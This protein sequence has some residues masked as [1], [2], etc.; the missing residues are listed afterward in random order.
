MAGGRVCRV[1]AAAARP[2]FSGTLLGRS[3]EYQECSACG[4]VQTETPTWLDQA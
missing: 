2:L 3:V 1:C 4:Y